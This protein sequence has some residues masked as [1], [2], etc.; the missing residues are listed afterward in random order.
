MFLAEGVSPTHYN[1]HS[2]SE[3]GRVAWGSSNLRSAQTALQAGHTSRHPCRL[4]LSPHRLRRRLHDDVLPWLDGA[5][6]HNAQSRQGLLP[7][8]NLAE[9]WLLQLLKLL[10]QLLLR[11]FAI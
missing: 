9:R 7:R 8:G 5:V 11:A 6:L 4:H 10:L 2:Y 3:Q 1:T